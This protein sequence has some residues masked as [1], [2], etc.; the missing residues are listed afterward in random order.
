MIIIEVL[1]EAIIEPILSVCIDIGYLIYD[2]LIPTSKDKPN[3]STA[4][5][6]ILAILGSIASGILILAILMD[7]ML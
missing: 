7:F 2:K 4:F 1:F 6:I 5:N 3:L